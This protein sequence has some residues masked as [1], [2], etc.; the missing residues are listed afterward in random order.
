MHSTA[1][2]NKE[3]SGP[4]CEQRQGWET[5][6]WVYACC[7]RPVGGADCSPC[8][9]ERLATWDQGKWVAEVSAGII[10][11]AHVW[12]SV[13]TKWSLLECKGKLERESKLLLLLWWPW[14]TLSSTSDP[15][16]TAELF[17]D[18]V[19]PTPLC[20]RQPW[21]QCYCLRPWSA[22]AFNT[23]VSTSLSRA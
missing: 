12:H 21:L 1:P 10:S 18:S 23:K 6:L 8:V 14:E 3:L 4:K 11:E 7:L 13:W 9:K 2:Q 16:E 20:S 17:P 15:L 22:A 19:S 5:F